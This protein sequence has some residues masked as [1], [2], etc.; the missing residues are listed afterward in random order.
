MDKKQLEYKVSTPAAGGAYIAHIGSVEGARRKAVR[1]A[2]ES[3]PDAKGA[4]IVIRDALTR[5]VVEEIVL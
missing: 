1:H 2:R 4:T 5:R 3:L